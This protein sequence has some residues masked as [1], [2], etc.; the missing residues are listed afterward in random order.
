MIYL[1][2]TRSYLHI[3]LFAI[4]LVG[5]TSNFHSFDVKQYRISGM[6]SSLKWVNSLIVMAYHDRDEIAMYSPHS[7]KK[8]TMVTR[9]D[10]ADLA[11]KEF[12]ADIMFTLPVGKV[13]PE[14]SQTFQFGDMFFC[15]DLEY[16]ISIIYIF[17]GTDEIRMFSPK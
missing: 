5:C 2:G 10:E 13:K 11:L 12:A 16:K 15:I 14:W 9:L 8:V 1:R 17:E 3:I 4:V 6:A 7:S